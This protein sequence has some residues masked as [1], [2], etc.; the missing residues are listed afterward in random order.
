[1][2]V[3]PADR[4]RQQRPNCRAALLGGGTRVVVTA[5]S[6]V[7]RPRSTAATFGVVCKRASIPWLMVVLLA[8]CSA[9]RV[10]GSPATMSAPTSAAA[11]N[12]PRVT[13]TSDPSRVASGTGVTTSAQASRADAR[14]RCAGSD[15]AA[16]ADPFVPSQ[17]SNTKLT[18]RLT[19][20]STSPCSLPDVPPTVSAVG[21]DGVV[22]TFDTAG[23]GTYFGDPAPLLGPLAPGAA[24]VVW[25]NGEAPGV[26]SDPR[27]VASWPS[28]RIGLPD[29]TTVG[30]TSGFDTSCGVLGVSAF[31]DAVSDP[32]GPTIA[33]ARFRPAP[34]VLRGL[35]LDAV[36]RLVPARIPEGLAAARRV[37][38]DG[39]EADPGATL[40]YTQL[41]ARAGAVV[42]I[43]TDSSPMDS[44]PPPTERVGRWSVAVEQ[45]VG[46]PLVAVTLSDT[47]ETG[48]IRLLATGL[49]VREIRSIAL[50]LRPRAQGPGWDPDDAALQF[51][52]EGW[53]VPRAYRGLAWYGADRPA[54]AE[55]Y[56]GQA[57]LLDA[58]WL[59]AGLGTPAT[60]DIRDHTTLIIGDAT[61]QIAVWQETPGIV[62]RLATR[63]IGRA[64]LTDAVASLTTTTNEPWTTIPKYRFNGDGC[65]ESLLC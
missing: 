20:V 53:P 65:G 61:L 64:D 31:G 30:F 8:G 1:M 22:V 12:G 44:A 43:T 27:S 34:E 28:W 24:A 10:A 17:S 50:G 40:A 6:E 42:Q 49:N 32:A 15:L 45:T 51:I 3:D 46:T 41:F 52:A 38:V 54:Q 48:S 18:V 39:D 2:L 26:C 59:A 9:R 11:T 35:T 33:W 25:I 16:V 23:K 47:M 5:G 21:D 57:Q 29:G 56:L 58:I 14:R 63:G 19:N 37:D 36:Q 13:S 62:G 55:L 4:H 7:T 60:I